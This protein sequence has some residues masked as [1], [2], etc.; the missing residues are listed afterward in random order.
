MLSFSSSK[1][2]P[3]LDSKQLFRWKVK[4]L[5]RLQSTCALTE[6]YAYRLGYFFLVSYWRRLIKLQPFRNLPACFPSKEDKLLPRTQAHKDH[7]L[8]LPVAGSVYSLPRLN[9]RT[10]HYWLLE[11]PFGPFLLLNSTIPGG[12]TLSWT[13]SSAHLYV[14][15]ILLCIFREATEW[16]KILMYFQFLDQCCQMVFQEAHT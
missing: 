2:C 1:D 11:G 10:T 9:I 15:I 3:M 7:H 16:T 8:I 12:K 5:F 14:N 4:H 6:V 13:H